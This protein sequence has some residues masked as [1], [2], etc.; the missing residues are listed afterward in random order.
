MPDNPF[1]AFRPRPADLAEWEDLLVRLELGPRALRLALDDIDR[2]SVS[3]LEPLNRL[4]TTEL[5]TSRALDTMRRGGG[6][7]PEK[8]GVSHVDP[9]DAAAG[10]RKRLEEYVSLRTDTFAAL[11][12]RGIQPW[13][14]SA[15]LEGGGTVTAYQAVR[16]ALQVDGEVLRAVR[17][18]GREE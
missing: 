14:W 4:V 1:D 7:V 10:A 16:R 3:L 8:I 11:Q 9:A 17:A 6:V 5:W 12:R 15:E 18:A 2:P 13:E